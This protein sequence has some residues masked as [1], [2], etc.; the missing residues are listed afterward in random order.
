[1][2]RHLREEVVHDGLDGVPHFLQPIRWRRHLE[3]CW[4]VRIRLGVPCGVVDGIVLLN[5]LCHLNLIVKPPP[6][7][8]LIY[9]IPPSVYYGIHVAINLENTA[10][11]T[12][13]N[14]APGRATDTQVTASDVKG[15][16]EQDRSTSVR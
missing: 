8:T 13:Q 1:M 5:M 11:K 4:S 9:E 7:S 10:R 14:Q 6:T 12:G 15:H 16:L 2:P 3:W